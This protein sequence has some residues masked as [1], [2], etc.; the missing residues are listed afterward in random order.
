MAT[1]G[2]ARSLRVFVVAHHFP[3][4]EGAMA[5]QVWRNVQGLASLGHSLIVFTSGGDGSSRA[6][7]G[8]ELFRSTRGESPLFWRVLTKLSR[9][10]ASLPDGHVGWYLMNRR[11]ALEA[12]ITWQSEVVYARS[13]PFSD[14]LLGRWLSGTTKLPLVV[15]LNEPWSSNP[16]EPR[17]FLRTRINA[18]MEARVL[19]DANAI[20]VNTGAH[21]S[22]LSTRYG[23]RIAAKLKVVSD[24]RGQV[25]GDPTGLAEGWASAPVFAHVGDFYGDRKAEPLLEAVAVLAREG[26]LPLGFR[27]VLVGHLPTGVEDSP[28]ARELGGYLVMTGY[29]SP[30]EAQ[31]WAKRSHVLISIDAPVAGGGL[32]MPSKL[33][34][35]IGMR[36]P[37]LALTSPGSPA[38]ALANSANGFTAAPG[39]VTAIASTMR[40]I[41]NLRIDELLSRVAGEDLRESLS[42][43]AVSSRVEAILRTTVSS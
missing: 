20:I 24:I 11:S 23:P 17:C 12:L 27:L 42:Q 39:D 30:D 38:D 29:V 2:E 37:V 41:L 18:R 34:E 3:P 26:S 43:E 6:A 14:L 10:L 8:T 28:L 21:A 33:I 19:A 25:E 15:H 7:N 36:R 16:Y 32:F 1:E 31:E 13:R 4:R 5:I 22:L 35:Y 40:G 9:C